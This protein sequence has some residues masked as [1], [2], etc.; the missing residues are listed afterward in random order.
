MLGLLV[1][2]NPI[3]DELQFI[4][5]LPSAERIPTSHAASLQSLEQSVREAGF[6]SISAQAGPAQGYGTAAEIGANLAVKQ[7][8]Y[9]QIGL[10]QPQKARNIGI[11]WVTA[12]AVHPQTTPNPTI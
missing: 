12:I 3:K 6:E 8:D 1:F 9:P 7:D 4:R 5:L 10:D 11:C 2:N